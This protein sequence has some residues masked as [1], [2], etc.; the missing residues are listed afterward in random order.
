LGTIGRFYTFCRQNDG[1]PPSDASKKGGDDG[2]P[3]FC[4]FLDCDD[5]PQVSDCTPAGVV[6]P[7]KRMSSSFEN[8]MAG[9]AESWRALRPDF[10]PVR[11][12]ADD[13][14]G[15][16]PSGWGTFVVSQWPIH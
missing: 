14:P 1:G 9:L 7:L 10:L 8:F 15:C 12:E 11:I 3:V 2:L 16:P 13:R 5:A 4:V 6:L